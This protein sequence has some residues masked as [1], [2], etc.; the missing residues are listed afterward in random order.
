MHRAFSL[1]VVVELVSTIERSSIPRLGGM[2][3]SLSPGNRP[4]AMVDTRSTTTGSERVARIRT[5]SMNE[6]G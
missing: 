6:K 1:P 5:K 3:A 4:P 2:Y